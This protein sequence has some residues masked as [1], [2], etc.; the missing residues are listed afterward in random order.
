MLK[1]I[2]MSCCLVI[3]IGVAP[4]LAHVQNESSLY[5]D[6]TYSE[7]KEEIV[8]LHGI[9]AIALEGGA[10][11]F[12][13]FEMLTLRDLAYW[14]GNFAG[15]GE[16]GLS[17]DD[18]REAALAAGLVGSLAGPATYDDVNQ[19]YYDGAAPVE[20][21]SGSLTREE[22][23]LYMG[24]FFDSEVDGM[25]LFERAGFVEG[26][27]GNVEDVEKYAVTEG[28]QTYDVFR[29]S[30]SGEWHQVSDHPKI[31]HGPVDL[32]QWVGK[33]IEASW[34]AASGEEGERA[35]EIIKVREAQFTQE[36]IE[37]FEELAN[38]HAGHEAT[39]DGTGQEEQGEQEG[40]GEGVSG[41]DPNELGASDETAGTDE[42]RT[43]PASDSDAVHASASEPASVD[44][45]AEKR[46]FPIPLVIG[47]GLFV[48]I[49]GWLLLRR[50]QA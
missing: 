43:A 19:A 13:P 28:G 31:V 12:K 33:A 4:V 27:R 26:P 2:W 42:A 41:A 40:H 34:L 16:D 25:T 32:S 35:L 14:A 24:R 10:N 6:I 11:L 48:L 37:A 44:V 50:K 17:A 46:P 38:A 45:Q 3:L 20:D 15:L 8:I 22:F 39:G 30:I 5:S 9:G 47:G 7:A 18:I 29:I 23:A 21:V 36:E 1:K 49:I